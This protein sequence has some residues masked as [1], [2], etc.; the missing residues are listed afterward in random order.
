M[1]KI[2]NDYMHAK[3]SNTCIK[4]PVVHVR[5]NQH[6]LKSVSLHNVAVGHCMEEEE[7]EGS[8]LLLLLLLCTFS[9]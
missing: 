1:Y 8:V 9:Q 6:G 5:V 2:Y 7:E 3:R 4:D